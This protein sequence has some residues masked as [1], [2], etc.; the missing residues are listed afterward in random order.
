VQFLRSLS[1]QS[2]YHVELVF[3][4]LTTATS[5][6]TYLPPYGEVYYPFILTDAPRVPDTDPKYEA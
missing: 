5:R 4:L 1:H 2:Q 3:G 6:T